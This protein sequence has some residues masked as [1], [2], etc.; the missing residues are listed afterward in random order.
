MPRVT[1]LIALAASVV[2]GGACAS[3]QPSGDPGMLVLPVAGGGRR[4]SM[5]NTYAAIATP[6]SVSADSAYEVLKRVYDLLDI[7]VTQESEKDRSVGNQD[8]RVRRNVAGLNMQDVLDCGRKLESPNAETWDIS[9]AVF[10]TAV[11]SKDGGSNIF[12]Q[13]QATGHEPSQGNGHWVPCAT[14][15][16][17]EEKIGAM[18]KSE[19]AK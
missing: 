9:M 19:I 16:A 10:S 13:I 15:S 18:V 4:G 7:P 3:S 2:A 8:L 14:T 5:T 11:A 17:L 1:A 6:V 12:T